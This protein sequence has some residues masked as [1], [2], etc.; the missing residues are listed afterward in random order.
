MTNRKHSFVLSCA[1]CQY[2]ADELLLL[3]TAIE[4]V[5]ALLRYSD[6]RGNHN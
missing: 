5:G 3:Y 4:A 6:I 2:F 1:L